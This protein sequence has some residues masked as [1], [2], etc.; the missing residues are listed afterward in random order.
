MPIPRAW[1]AGAVPGTWFIPTSRVCKPQC[2]ASTEGHL[3]LFL[4][5][6]C[7]HRAAFFC[8][9]WLRDKLCLNKQEGD[10][11]GSFP[12]LLSFPL[13]FWLFLSF[14]FIP[15][16][17]QTLAELLRLRRGCS[18]HKRAITF[19]FAER[20]KRAEAGAGICPGDGVTGTDAARPLLASF[21][22]QLGLL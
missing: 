7:F 11:F 20:G 22:P 9:F 3:L 21:V 1:C 6:A 2:P 8:P 5:P 17:A 14:L 10:F 16:G 4:L 19:H 12:S 15:S 18:S 13:V